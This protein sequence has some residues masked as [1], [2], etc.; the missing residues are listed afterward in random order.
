MKL[1]TLKD[2]SRDGT[3]IVVSRDLKHAIKADDIAD[4]TFEFPRLIAHAARTRLRPAG[5]YSW[6]TGEWCAA[7]SAENLFQ[8]KVC[9]PSYSHRSACCKIHF[10]TDPKRCFYP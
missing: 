4:M 5:G 6:S 1:A 9:L 2:G 3:L 10:A 8:T 7:Y